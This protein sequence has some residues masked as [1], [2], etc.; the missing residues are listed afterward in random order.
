[1]I[2]MKKIAMSLIWCALLFTVIAVTMALFLCDQIPFLKEG[3]N[4]LVK[5]WG[6]RVVPVS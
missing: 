4:H 6:T 5:F 3:K 2:I 1:M